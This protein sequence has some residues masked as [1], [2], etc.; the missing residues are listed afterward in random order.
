MADTL[1]I[2]ATEMR[3][4]RTQRTEEKAA[5]LPVKMIFPIIICFMPVFLIV[6]LVP[7][8]ITLFEAL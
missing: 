1:R 4:K 8:L 6:I 7:A 3:L 5:K 2:Q